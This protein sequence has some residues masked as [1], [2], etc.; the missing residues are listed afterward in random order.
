MEK[1]ESVF[2]VKPYNTSCL[3]KVA[4][5]RWRESDYKLRQ[6][7]NSK[8]FCFRGCHILE[9]FAL[10]GHERS[11]FYGVV[12]VCWSQY[13]EQHALGR[14][15]LQCTCTLWMGMATDPSRCFWWVALRRCNMLLRHL[16]CFCG[17]CSTV[18]LVVLGMTKERA[19]VRGEAP[20]CEYHGC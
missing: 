15:T 9:V 2:W 4:D 3:G 10:P 16:A 14:L 13:Y 11:E 8:E 1:Y 5:N 7:T 12:L 20:Y 19:R 17:R 18:L 6:R